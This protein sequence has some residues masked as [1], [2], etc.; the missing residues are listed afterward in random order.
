MG[1]DYS[2]ISE[3][4]INYLAMRIEEDYLKDYPDNR[5]SVEIQH[6]EVGNLDT[7]SDFYVHFSCEGYLPEKENAERYPYHVGTWIG[8]FQHYNHSNVIENMEG[9]VHWVYRFPGAGTTVYR[10]QGA[11]CSS[12]L[13]LKD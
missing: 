2:Q 5:G 13:L 4:S 7:H 3:E 11:T 6:V 9:K 1:K 10:E 12:P 8:S